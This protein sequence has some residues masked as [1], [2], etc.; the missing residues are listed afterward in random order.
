MTEPKEG[1]LSL[2][3]DGIVLPKHVV[4]IMKDNKEVYNFSAFSLL[5]S[6]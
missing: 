4:A 6:T 3:E 1:K 2:P 5:I